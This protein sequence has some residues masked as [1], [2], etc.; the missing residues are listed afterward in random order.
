MVD[1]V[2]SVMP[3]KQ[4]EALHLAVANWHKEMTKDDLGE[5]MK[6]F[7]IIVHHYVMA[8]KEERASAELMMLNLLGGDYIDK[9]VLE[10]VKPMLGDR[11]VNLGEEDLMGRALLALPAV[12]WLRGLAK[13]IRGQQIGAVLLRIGNRFRQFFE[14][15]R[16]RKAAGLLQTQRALPLGGLGAVKEGGG[17]GG[18]E[19]EGGGAGGKSKSKK[20]TEELSAARR[21]SRSDHVRSLRRSSL[22]LQLESFKGIGLEGDGEPAGSL[23]PT[24]VAFAKNA[25]GH[26]STP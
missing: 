18:E 1:T 5:R 19:E 23:T 4:R 21:E 7:P 22:T 12:P 20:K 26:A 6:R 24:R 15:F 3:F 11:K 25:G 14:N 10:E 16:K 9:W 13:A 8:N 2:I 17:E